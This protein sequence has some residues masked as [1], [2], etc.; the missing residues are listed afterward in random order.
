MADWC[1]HDDVPRSWTNHLYEAFF[2]GCRAAKICG[3]GRVEMGGPCRWGAIRYSES[4][5]LEGLKGGMSY[6]WHH[7]FGGFGTRRVFGSVN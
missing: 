7:R 4:L 6:F 3:L 2:A 1:R 5:G